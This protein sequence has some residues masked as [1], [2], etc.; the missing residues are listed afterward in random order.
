MPKLDS[1]KKDKQM[2]LFLFC[3]IVLGFGIILYSAYETI[4]R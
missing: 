3:V 4:K 2:G 1:L